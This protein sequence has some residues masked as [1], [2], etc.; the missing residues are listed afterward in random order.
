MHRL[1]ELFED[2]WLRYY[3]LLIAVAYAYGALVHVLNM[4][5]TM[6]FEWPNAPLKWQVLDVAYL[7]IDVA[8]MIGLI[9]K[10][11]FGIIAF[12]I[13]SVSQILL[14]TVFRAWIIDV[15]LE[16]APTVEQVSY[17]TTLVW[18]HVITLGIFAIL[19]VRRWRLQIHRSH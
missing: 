18:F 16:F 7:V 19:L 6:G 3:L 10:R 2:R 13:G 17:L 9:R 1:S 8:A 14:Y 11:A 4:L 5:S 15:P 12:L